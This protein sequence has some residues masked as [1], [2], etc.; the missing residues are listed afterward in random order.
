MSAPKELIEFDDF[1]E[2]GDAGVPMVSVKTELPDEG[3]SSA[4]ASSEGPAR[5]AGGRSLCVVCM[6]KPCKGKDLACADCTK[7]VAAC[8]RSAE[9]NNNLDFFE[10][11][12]KNDVSFRRM[13]RQYQEQCPS[14]GSGKSRDSFE[15][16]QFVQAHFTE[17][18][19][20]DDNQGEWLDYFGFVAYQVYSRMKTSEQADDMWKKELDRPGVVKDENG[21]EVGYPDRIQMRTH[22]FVGMRSSGGTRQEA[23][24]GTKQARGAQAHAAHERHESI[25]GSGHA[26]FQ[27]ELH[28]RIGTGFAKALG[29]HG[30]FAEAPSRVNPIRPRVKEEP[31]PG[32][33]LAGSETGGNDGK[34]RKKVDLGLFRLRAH[35]KAVEQLS[36]IRKD[37]VKALDDAE[38][39]R[40]EVPQNDIQFQRFSDFLQTRAEVAKA[41]DTKDKLK[42]IWESFDEAQKMR[43]PCANPSVLKS[44]EEFD[45]T[46]CAG[47]LEAATVEAVHIAKEVFDEALQIVRQLIVSVAA[48]IKDCSRFVAVCVRCVCALCV[49]SCAWYVCRGSGRVVLYRV[50]SCRVVLYRVVSF[51]VVSCRAMPCRVESSRVVSLRV[52]PLRVVSCRVASCR[53]LSCR[54]VSC[55][56][57]SRVCGWVVP[58]R[59]VSCRGVACRSVSHHTVACRVVSSRAMSF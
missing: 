58:C 24:Q 53:V 54:V 38:T 6:A 46:V 23:Q 34:K 5:R 20:Y 28:H 41:L 21:R 3:S 31:S 1:D 37:V 26:S 47:I 57:A 15:W 14:R 29:T 39:C 33:T 59:V 36:I 17:S 2:G 13:I 22:D 12:K 10:S 19:S 43:V 55:R 48:A 50:A 32:G 51:R 16:A 49:V 52:V 44:F 9:G 25:L 4:A 7:D 56:A 30:N 35:E 18:A 27:G 11:Q 42:Q 45:T 40:K 8:K